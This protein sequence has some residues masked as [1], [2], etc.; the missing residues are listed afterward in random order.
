[1]RPPL[2]DDT[3]L[4]PTRRSHGVE[5]PFLRSPKR[6]LSRPPGARAVLRMRTTGDGR[7]TIALFVNSA[8]S[9]PRPPRPRGCLR[10]YAS[11]ACGWRRSRWAN[12]HRSGRSSPYDVWP[13]ASE[14]I[15]RRSILSARLPGYRRQDE[16]TGRPDGGRRRVGRR[17]RRFPDPRHLSPPHAWWPVGA[18]D[19][20]S[21]CPAGPRRAAQAVLSVFGAR[22]LRAERYRRPFGNVQPVQTAPST[23]PG[24]H[25]RPP[26]Y[27][28]DHRCCGAGE[29]GDRSAIS[30][31]SASSLRASSPR[32]G[33]RLR[34]LEDGSDQL[35]A[36]VGSTTASLEW[37]GR[38]FDRERAGHLDDRAFGRLI[39][40]RWDQ[41]AADRPMIDAGSRYAAG[42]SRD[43]GAR[44]G[45]RANDPVMLTDR[46]CPDRQAQID[47]CTHRIAMPA[48]LTRMSSQP[49]RSNVAC[50]IASTLA[51]SATS[52]TMAVTRRPSA[53]FHGRFLGRALVEIGR[54]D[55]RARHGQRLRG[56]RPIPQARR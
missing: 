48:L 50:T 29:E 36:H 44:G 51:S 39:K 30:A 47:S 4:A 25:R 32:C 40:T 41:A 14:R 9:G 6:R 34:V 43:H 52:A 53:R 22:P 3:V 8:A 31:G 21:T 10:P 11:R 20:V 24:I 16:G 7:D 42:A 1:M 13:I 12:R 26:A 15:L 18:D 2:I 19:L 33:G 27:V 49:S 28:R 54:H 17:R 45:A 5:D 55:A 37:R 56:S 35:G 23:A 38:P 46:T